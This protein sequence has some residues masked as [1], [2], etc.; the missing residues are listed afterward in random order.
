M[1]KKAELTISKI[2]QF[3]QL[4]KTPPDESLLRR[5]FS[6]CAG[7][8]IE[9]PLTKNERRWVS[10][11]MEANPSWQEKWTELENQF[12]ESVDWKAEAWTP[13]EHIDIPKPQRQR[14]TFAEL[15]DVFVPVPALRFAAAAAPVIIVL[16]GG[17]RVIG[18]TTLSESYHLASISDYENV[19]SESVRGELST[20][21][22]SA[23]VRELL[24]AHSDWFGLFP[25][26]DLT[27]I[28]NA[29]PQLRIAF[30]DTE[31]EFQRTEIA[32]FL[33]KAYL[34]KED[35]KSAKKWLNE[36]L[37][38]NVADYR[39]DAAELLKKLDAEFNKNSK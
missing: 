31:D 27:R 3:L 17:L 37:A 10:L 33:A 36:V 13:P 11:N 9:S 4:A 32:F 34:M 22:F 20:S 30:Q 39:E 5:F 35:A 29:I 23:G 2:D 12:G 18:T 15:F 6:A 19:L 14:R 25:H 16:Y 8:E 7:E 28:D 38:Q 21:E 26:Y 24:A 1:K